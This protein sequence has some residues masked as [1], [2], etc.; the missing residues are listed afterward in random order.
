MFKK[1]KLS[2]KNKD[3]FGKFK[4]T[5]NNC[6]CIVSKMLFSNKI[7]IDGKIDF[8][9]QLTKEELWSYI[10]YLFYN[11]HTNVQLFK[12]MKN[13]KGKANAELFY[14]AVLSRLEN[15]NSEIP[16]NGSVALRYAQKLDNA[17]LIFFINTILDELK[18]ELVNP[19]IDYITI[20]L[21]KKI[22][23]KLSNISINLGKTN[24]QISSNSKNSNIKIKVVSS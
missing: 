2:F 22:I 7:N 20:L 19:V 12:D 10:Y 3:I 9:A 21:N 23:P 11:N 8:N 24:S 13:A 15:K 18:D 17:T 4:P 16:A 5:I 1:Q 14:E 6:F